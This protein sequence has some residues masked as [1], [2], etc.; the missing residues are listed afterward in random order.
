MSDV[1][2]TAFAICY[3]FLILTHGPLFPVIIVGG[4]GCLFILSLF[5][6]NCYLWEFF[7]GQWIEVSVL[8]IGFIFAYAT[9]L[10]MLEDS[11]ILKTTLNEVFHSKD[12]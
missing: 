6:L 12:S 10:K 1:F 11:A 4:G 7:E 2:R 9:L 3:D 5:L 8:H